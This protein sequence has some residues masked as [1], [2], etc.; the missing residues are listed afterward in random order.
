MK[1]NT[2]HTRLGGLDC[3]VVDALPDGAPTD[4]LVV[5]CH[6]Y[7]ASG[8]DLVPL[9]SELLAMRPEV[10]G[11]ARFVFPVAP[12][13]LGG[14]AFYDM[15]AWWHLDMERIERSIRQGTLRDLRGDV[16]EGLAKARRLL[17]ALIDEAARA[18]GVGLDRLV[19]GGFS[20]GA[21]L[22]TDVA[23]RLE[24][25]PRALAVLSGTLLCE[26]QWR[27]LAPA[28]RGLRVLQ[29]H[30]RRD[31]L[32]PYAGAEWLRD[33]LTEAGLAVELLPFD[34]GHTIPATVVARLAFVLASC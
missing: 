11:R 27:R 2:I 5:L 8:A 31:E 20:Q 9:G 4:L 25:A 14:P 19:L 7:G 18:F 26:E 10:A 1:P 16:P 22:A 30:G 28:R 23:L 33:L 12:L 32:L 6:G 21:M 29:S 17:R 24:E 15:R 34:D 13:S 3:A